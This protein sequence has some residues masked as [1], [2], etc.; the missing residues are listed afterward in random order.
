MGL[1]N[2]H[3]ELESKKLRLRLIIN[4]AGTI[5]EVKDV[6]YGKVSTKIYGRCLAKKREEL[7]IKLDEFK[8]SKCQKAY[9][10]PWVRDHIV[11][12]SLPNDTPA[13]PVFLTPHIDGCIIGFK[14]RDRQ[15]DVCHCNFES[16]SPVL[17]D[18]YVLWLAP[19]DD[20][21]SKKEVEEALAEKNVIR[22]T[23]TDYCALWGEYN[24]SQWKFY[25]QLM[26]KIVHEIILD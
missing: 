14:K 9:I 11:E 18:N 15:I 21:F 17:S 5:P 23:K 13:T 22:Y 10:L 1:E 24:D 2:L 16:V 19:E 4:S 7:E 26:D 12:V 3:S 20:A 8:N 6:H 25:Y